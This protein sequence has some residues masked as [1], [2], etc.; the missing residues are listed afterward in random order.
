MPVLHDKVIG[1]YDIFLDLLGK[2]QMV[3]FIRN[4]V[5]IPR[6]WKNDIIERFFDLKFILIFSTDHLDLWSRNSLPLVSLGLRH[7]RWRED[8]L[9]IL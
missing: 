1:F 9:L 3:S 4:N 2:D 8:E 6:V 7:R 5:Q